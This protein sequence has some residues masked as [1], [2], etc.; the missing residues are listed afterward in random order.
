M[1][2][3]G[4]D[5][6]EFIVLSLRVLHSRIDDRFFNIPVNLQKDCHKYRELSLYKSFVFKIADFF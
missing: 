3:Y 4:L 5:Q 1:P 2:K 6:I